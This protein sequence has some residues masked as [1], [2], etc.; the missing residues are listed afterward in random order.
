MGIIIHADR[1]ELGVCAILE[2]GDPLV[3]AVCRSGQLH[4][5]NDK[6]I[7]VIVVI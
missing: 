5:N 2:L 6:S 7:L 3:L 4:Y 1:S